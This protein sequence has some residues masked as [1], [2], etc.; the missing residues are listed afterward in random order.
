M[1]SDMLLFVPNGVRNAIHDRLT[2]AE[3]NTNLQ[4]PVTLF[5]VKECSPILWKPMLRKKSA[6]MGGNSATFHI[7]VKCG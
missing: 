5:T 2:L 6:K 7:K 4:H 1:L 3:A